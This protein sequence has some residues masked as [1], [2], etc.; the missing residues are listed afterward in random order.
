MSS[1]LRVNILRGSTA[2][3]NITIQGE[4]TSNLGGATIQLQQGL[5]KAWARWDST[6]N[7]GSGTT[8]AT[9]SFGV[10]SL[11]DATTG[12]NLVNLTNAMTDTNYP[13][14]ALAQYQD[15]AGLTIAEGP[16]GVTTSLYRIR[17]RSGTAT[18]TGSEFVSTV[19]FGDLA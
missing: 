7:D 13:V 8:T 14:T 18:L 10:S 15:G 12:T 9:D 17:T 19:L 2:N 11:T 4:G 5:A 1:E 3:G 6:G 16:S